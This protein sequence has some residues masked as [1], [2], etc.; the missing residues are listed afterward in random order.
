MAAPKR[1]NDDLMDAL[2]DL[3]G[4]RM[5]AAQAVREQH[6]HDESYHEGHAPDL[7]VFP[8]TTEEVNIPTITKRKRQSNANCI[9]SR[10]FV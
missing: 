4:D 8:N 1:I 5:S 9:S 3:L 7:V 2:R 6:G 10:R